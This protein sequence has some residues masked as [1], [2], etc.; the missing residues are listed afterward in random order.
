MDEY[1]ECWMSVETSVEEIK[2][3]V[4][5][6]ADDG[7]L[8]GILAYT[9]DPIVSSDIVK[10]PFSSIFDAEQYHEQLARAAEA[11]R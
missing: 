11:I 5:G 6:K 4:R 10:N 7:P 9:E 3:L 8:A 2:E 1:G